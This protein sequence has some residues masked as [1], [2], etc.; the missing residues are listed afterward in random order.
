MLRCLI[1]E[2]LFCYVLHSVE[3]VGMEY[4]AVSMYMYEGPGSWNLYWFLIICMI[5]LHT[6]I[7]RKLDLRFLQMYRFLPVT[8]SSVLKPII[9]IHCN[10][11]SHI[12]T[13]DLKYC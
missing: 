6:F 2:P 8:R 3:L 10:K 13:M 12:N 5:F 7:G 4:H 11:A 9:F 1:V